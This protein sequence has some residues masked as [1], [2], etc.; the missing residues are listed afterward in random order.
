MYPSTLT[1]ILFV[2]PMLLI[3]FYCIPARCKNT[4]LVAASILLYSWGSPIRVLFPLAYLFFDYGAGMLLQKLQGQKIPSRIVLL[5]SVLL[6]TAALMLVRWI[7]AN[8]TEL[9]LPFGA[10][11]YT[12]QGIGYLIG[13]YRRKHGAEGNLLHLALFLFFYPILFAGPLFGYAEYKSQLTER[14]YNILHLGAG[15]GLFVRG[16][17]KKVILADTLGYVFLELRQTETADISMLTAW[18]TVTAFALYLYFELSGFSDMAR[19]LGRCFGIEL[20]KNFGQPFFSVSVTAFMENWNI[21]HSFWFQ[22]NFRHF[23]FHGSKQKWIR[24]A[25]IVLMWALIG[26]WYGSTPLF[27]LWGVC[28]GIL[29]AVERLFLEKIINRNHTFGMLYTGIIM[30]FLWVL[31]FADNM[32]ETFGIWKAMIGFGNGLADRHGIYFFTSYLVFLLICVYIAT[33]LFHNI[34]ERIAQTAVGKK[35]VT[36]S[37]ILTAIILLLSLASMLYTNG[38]TVPWLLL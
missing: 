36:L 34:T 16:L 33:D 12:L 2:L 25:S 29:I 13:I 17:A 6:Q 19:G 15:L 14:R 18:L 24:Y 5:M 23:L 22:K 38:I 11:I 31:M 30:P 27:L 3:L 7:P 32:A 4:Y 20:P 21:T 35:I 1:F 8:G 37:P 26:F 10:A 28:I 9:L